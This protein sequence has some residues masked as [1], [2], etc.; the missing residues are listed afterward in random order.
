MTSSE[1]S[2][3]FRN[4]VKEWQV[5]VQASDTS[6]LGQPSAAIVLPYTE[7]SKKRDG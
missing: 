1:I 6:I 4:L 7:A 2:Q 3:V 5:T